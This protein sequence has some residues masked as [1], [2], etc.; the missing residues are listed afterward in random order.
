MLSTLKVHATSRRIS[1]TF[2]FHQ[3][4]TYYACPNTCAGST[5]VA[6]HAG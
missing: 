6:R 3:T 4:L 2:L 1:I 5:L